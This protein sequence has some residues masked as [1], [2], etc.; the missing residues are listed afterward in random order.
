MPK[1]TNA[2]LRSSWCTWTRNRSSCS[3][4]SAIGVDRE[5]A[6]TTASAAP[7]RAADARLPDGAARI[8]QTAGP[9]TSL[10]YSLG[11]RVCLQ[12]ALDRADL[13]ERLVLVSASPG[14][15]DPVQREQRRV[16]DCA[17]AERIAQLGL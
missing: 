10:G 15:E 17:L 12:L 1:A 3:N 6:H 2:P 13:V 14:I 7:A 16:S 11:G 5:P 4:A 9:G 8:D